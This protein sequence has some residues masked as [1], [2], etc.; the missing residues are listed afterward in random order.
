MKC[1]MVVIGAGP[2]G[3]WAAKIAADEGLDVVVLEDHGA[4]G[5]PKHC[6]GWLLGCGEF[7]DRIFAEM[8]DALPHQ[9]V[10]RYKVIDALTGQVKEDI[11]DT[12]WG[13]YLVRR[14][15][16]D[17]EL[18]KIA[19]MAGVKLFLNVNVKE[20]IKEDGYVVGVRTTS[21]SLPEVRAKV[22]ICADGIK[23]ATAFGFAS[24][25][26]LSG[27]KEETYSGV[28]MELV[29]VREVTPG[30]IEM[31]EGEDPILKGRAFYPH[32][33]G[34]TLSA[35]PSIKAF[36]EIR[37]RRDN[38]LSRKLASS[39]PVYMG[40]YPMRKAMG[41]YYDCMVKDGVIFVGDACGC[42]GI[43]HG[44]I[45]GSYAAQVVKKIIEQENPKIIYEYESL[46]KNSDIYRNPYCYHHINEIYGSYKTWLERSREIRV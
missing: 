46:V 45:T 28:K 37:S 34:I 43:I 42:S 31:Y 2:A 39:F 41:L 8:K 19:L 33:W 38:L 26:L 23:S 15:L 3:L 22:T 14:E 18:A 13:G 5:L 30:Q 11:E 16:F 10:T 7:T 32:G 20:L 12:G 24:K 35:F 27:S 21:N 1:D 9:K 29:N 44:M 40:G 25:E 36:Q 6:S 17:R 4:V